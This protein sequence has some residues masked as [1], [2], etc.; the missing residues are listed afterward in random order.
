MHLPGIFQL[1]WK[2]R[3]AGHYDLHKGWALILSSEDKVRK[4]EHILQSPFS[5]QIYPQSM[6][7]SSCTLWVGKWIL[8]RPSVLSA[9][10]SNITEQHRM[11]C[12]TIQ[13]EIGEIEMAA[14]LII[15]HG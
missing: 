5:T 7:V 1:L 13:V 11:S 4:Q 14:L 3:G 10:V 2:I 9:C 6:C 8:R 12:K 15:L